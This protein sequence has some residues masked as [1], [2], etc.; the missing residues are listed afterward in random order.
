MRRID[1]QTKPRADHAH[2][3]HVTTGRETGERR[4]LRATSLRSRAAA[5]ARRCDRGRR[6]PAA[7]LPRR[8]LRDRLQGQEQ[9]GHH[10]RLRGRQQAQARFCATPFPTTDGFRRRPP[11]TTSGLRANACGSSI[12]STAPRNLSRAFRSSWSRSRWPK[13]ACRSWASPTIRSSTS[14]SGPRA[15]R[16][17]ISTASRSRSAAPGARA[18]RPCSRAAAK[19][20]AANGRPTRAS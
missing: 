9:S 1:D 6:N 19:P 12:R 13:T 3:E 17:A 2:R 11:I 20:R 7:L 18:L 4:P 16:D 10:R 14:C 15:A 5:G 8:R